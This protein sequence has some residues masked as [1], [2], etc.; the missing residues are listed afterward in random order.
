MPSEKN[1]AEEVQ[2]LKS[3]VAELTLLNELALA[4]SSAGDV[5]LVLE[6]IIKKSIKAVRAEQGS[7][8]LVTAQSDRPLRTLIRKEDRSDALR[9]YKVGATIT[10]WVL[11]Y[12]QSLLVEDLKKDKRFNLNQNEAQDIHSLLCVPVAVR[13]KMIGVLTVTNKT[14]G[15][16]FSQNDLRLMSIIAAQSGQLIQNSQLQLESIEKKRLEHQ[17][18]LARDIQLRLLPKGDPS[19]QCYDIAS[20]FKPA[21]AVGGDYFDYFQLDANKLGVVIADVSGHGPPAALVMTMMK[22]ILHSITHHFHSAAETLE[23]INAIISR[24]IPADIFVTMQFLMFN[25]ADRS[26]TIANAGHNPVLHYVKEDQKCRLID[27]RGCVLNMSSD[28]KYTSERVVLNSGDYILIYTDGI[29]ESCNKNEEMFRISGLIHTIEKNAHVPA[30]TMIENICQEIKD[31]TGDL[32]QA[33]D[34]IIVAFRVI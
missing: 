3:A 27:T 21:D 18:D 34:M 13:G 11:K 20:F 26:L 32:P 16:S 7:I 23:E 14:G 2:R 31:F 8:M 25:P 4:V 33:D 6:T 12:Q 17:L 24:I 19:D 22:G 30:K 15:E 9:S 1:L 28:S 29:N 5:D 10:G